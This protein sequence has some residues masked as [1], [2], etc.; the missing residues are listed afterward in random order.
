M[1]RILIT[2][3]T[4]NVGRE[5]AAALKK[6]NVSM[7]C[8]VRNIEK[9]K[10]LFFNEYDFV[11]LDFSNRETFDKALEDIECIFL[12]Y[13][14]ETPFDD[15][16]AFIRRAKEKGVRHITYLSVKD[17]QFLPFV[18]HHKNEKAIVQAGIS[19]TFLRAGYFTQNLNMFLLDEL[20]KND[21]IYVPCGKGKTSFVDLRDI[22]EV[23][24]ITLLNPDYHLNQKYVLTGNKAL[25]F[26]EVAEIM[27][28]FLER[29]IIYSNPSLNEFKKYMMKK[30]YEAKYVN[31]VG[32]LHF[33]TKLGMA[34]SVKS[35][36][37]QILGRHPI[38]VEEYVNDYKEVWRKN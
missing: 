8:A 7:V 10:K 16:H 14:P 1:G 31:L 3:I 26:F 2:G 22:G 25:D 21:R 36:L 4:G 20:V 28:L 17:V 29:K 34:K 27:T 30:G 11:S 9:A 19:F 15:F 38:T 6:R 18:P 23:A 12:N 5:V 24:A 37:S 33:F 13:P 35:D 32:S